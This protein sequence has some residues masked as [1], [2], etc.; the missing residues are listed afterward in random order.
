MLRFDFLRSDFHPHFLILGE[1]DDL[2]LLAAELL[3]LSKDGKQ[4]RL[5]YAPGDSQSEIVLL[6]SCSEA[7]SG[8]LR[9]DKKTFIWEVSSEHAAAFSEEILS[10]A[11]G[12]QPAGSAVL[13]VGRF[14]LQEIPVWISQGEF[15]DNYLVDSY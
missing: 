7:P 10:V 12:E 11:E 14:D 5:E 6:V 4:R 13:S 8:L 3:G 9:T 15:T 1:R 2:K